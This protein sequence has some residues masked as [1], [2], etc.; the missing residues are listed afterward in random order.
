LTC[1]NQN[2][3]LEYKEDTMKK[4]LIISASAA[5]VLLIAAVAYKPIARH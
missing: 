1:N 4:N 5:A 3:V 2:K